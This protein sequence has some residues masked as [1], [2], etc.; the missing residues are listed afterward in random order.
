MLGCMLSSYRNASS[1][2]ERQNAFY[3]YPKLEAIYYPIPFVGSACIQDLPGILR[4][5]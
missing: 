1:L 5:Q 4:D 2:K 3:L